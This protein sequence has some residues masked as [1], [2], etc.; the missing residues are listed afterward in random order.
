[1]W[2][3]SEL[4]IR[5]RVVVQPR[6]CCCLQ[7]GAQSSDYWVLIE[8]SINTVTGIHFSWTMR[9]LIRGKSGLNWRRGVNSHIAQPLTERWTLFTSHVAA[10]HQRSLW[11]H[12]E[13]AS[14]HFTRQIHSLSL[15]LDTKHWTV[16][17]SVLL[18][19]LASWVDSLFKEELGF[20]VWLIKKKKKTLTPPQITSFGETLKTA[21]F[22]QKERDV[23]SNQ[24]NTTLYIKF[25]V[26][27]RH[28]SV[29]VVPPRFKRLVCEYGGTTAAGTELDEVDETCL[30]N[31]LFYT[32]STFLFHSV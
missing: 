32:V 13:T 14:P 20:I 1:M 3:F 27:H 9:R 21:E 26:G 17:T 8:K 18:A 25:N 29:S 28:G 23:P 10:I 7:F 12:E 6:C 16:C 22:H 4:V 11:R 19:C 24:E 31:Q 2:H 15:R 30:L 5:R